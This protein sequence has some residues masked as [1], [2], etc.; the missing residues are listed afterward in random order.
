MAPSF[1]SSTPSAANVNL[2]TTSG[3][4]TS[5]VRYGTASGNTNGIYNSSSNSFVYDVG[6]TGA[7]DSALNRFRMAAYLVSQYSSFP[8]GPTSGGS[9]DDAIQRAIWK[10][11]YNNTGTNSLNFTFSDVSS[12][13]G[14]GNTWIDLARSFVLNANNSSFFNNWAVVSWT[15][16]STGNLNAPNTPNYQTFLVQIVPEPGFYGMLALGLSGLAVAIGRRR[17]TA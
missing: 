4:V 2:L 16:D 13:A 17:R 6:L 7:A 10:I 8:G 15:V 11:M 1:P 5:Q 12:G 14:S 9:T 3:F